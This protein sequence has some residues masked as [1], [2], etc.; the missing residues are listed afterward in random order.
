MKYSVLIIDDEEKLRSLLKRIISLEGYAVYDAADIAHG[1]Q[2]MVAQEMYD[3]K[4]KCTNVDG[5]FL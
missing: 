3:V 2:L 1:M 4:R 5:E